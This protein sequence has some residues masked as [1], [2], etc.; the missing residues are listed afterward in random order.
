M[1]RKGTASQKYGERRVDKRKSSAVNGGLPGRGGSAGADDSERLVHDLRV[2]QIEMEM[3]NREL[4]EANGLL[5]ASRARYAELY[6]RAPVAYLT[7]DTSGRIRE[8]N[9]SAG[10]LLSAAPN[11]VIGQHFRIFVLAD[12]RR[13]FDA[14]LARSFAADVPTKGQ[15]RVPARGA[16]R[17][18]ELVLAPFV[19]PL[20]GVPVCHVAAVDV[21]IRELNAKQRTK[22]LR[23]EREAR[24]AAETA[25]AMKEE[26]LAVVSHE[27]R[28][29]LGPMLMWL[30]ILQGPKVDAGPPRAR[31]AEHHRLRSGP[32]SVDRRSR[33]YGARN[34]RQAPDQPSARGPR[35]HR[36]RGDRANRDVGGAQGGRGPSAAICGRL[37]GVRRLPTDSSR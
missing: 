5:E 28:T 4:R 21:T 27:L 11:A 19:D 17:V 23:L 36:L 1:I 2:H 25:S 3:Q 8:A 26:F 15:V 14:I 29:P 32:S 6:D 13:A 33:R 24:A 10:S 16:T 30:D 22:L 34:A 7:L 18:I 9:L 20:D 35:A 12:G 31:R 37:S